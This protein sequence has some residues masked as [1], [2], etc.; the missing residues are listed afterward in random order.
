MLHMKY[1]HYHVQVS[2]GCLAT[3]Q[4]LEM[5]YLLRLYFTVARQQGT[6]LIHVFKD[7]VLKYRMYLMVLG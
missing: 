6:H 2:H 7:T 5:D 1:S 4:L 3:R